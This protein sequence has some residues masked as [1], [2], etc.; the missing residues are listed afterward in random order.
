MGIA[1]D[2]TYKENVSLPKAGKE[3]RPFGHADE[4]FRM[5]YLVATDGSE[6]ST[7]AVAYAAKHAA[8]F[9]RELEIV[10]VL[11]P[12]TELIGDELVLQDRNTATEE[13]ERI[14]DRATETAREAVPSHDLPIE[15]GLLTGKPARAIAERATEA[16]ADAIFIGHR[17]LTSK[18]E[19]MVGSVAKQVVSEA[20]VPVTVVR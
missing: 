20:T 13:G 16:G 19:S 4:S 6:E 17:G 2:A 15:T 11:M 3:T 18:Q 5:R 10:H 1:D 12:E 9:E 7:D 8:T 14:L